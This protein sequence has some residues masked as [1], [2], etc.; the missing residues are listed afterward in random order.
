MAMKL[1][2]W[3]L[4]TGARSATLVAFGAVVPLPNSASTA[5]TTRVTVSIR[6]ADVEHHLRAL[7]E[8]GGNH[9][10]H[11]RAVGIRP[12]LEVLIATFE[13]LAPSAFT[14]PT[15]SAPCATA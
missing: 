4:D 1:M 8:I 7:G 5:S 11:R 14:P 6:L 9:P 15:T 12:L 10:F 2:R 13:P 3:L